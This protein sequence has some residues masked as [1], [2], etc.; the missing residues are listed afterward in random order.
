MGGHASELQH[1]AFFAVDRVALPM[2]V[3]RI[4]DMLMRAIAPVTIVWCKVLRLQRK[5]D[6][7]EPKLRRK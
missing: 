4:H 7:A 6:A 1:L 2:T 3:T 5:E